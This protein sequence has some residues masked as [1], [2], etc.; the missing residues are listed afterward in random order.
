MEFRTVGIEGAGEELAAEGAD[1]GEGA[2]PSVAD[3]RAQGARCDARHDESCLFW[4]LLSRK[5]LS[6]ALTGSFERKL[7]KEGFNCRDL[8]HTSA[9]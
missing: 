5:T 8:A 4:P 2:R 6:G 7:L 3:R 1:F 9:A